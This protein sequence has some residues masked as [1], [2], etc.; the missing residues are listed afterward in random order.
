[1]SMSEAKRQKTSLRTCSSGMEGVATT[2]SLARQ[3]VPGAAIGNAFGSEM[4]V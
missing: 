4:S 2:N 3:G 1:M